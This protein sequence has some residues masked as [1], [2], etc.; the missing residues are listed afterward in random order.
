M[1][2]CVAIADFI[3]DDGNLQRVRRKDQPQLCVVDDYVLEL[4]KEELQ[5]ERVSDPKEA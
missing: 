4:K 5:D 1:N 3:C 2:R